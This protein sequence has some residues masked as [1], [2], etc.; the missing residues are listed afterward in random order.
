M[1]K[2]LLVVKLIALCI[3][4]VLAMGLVL[5]ACSDDSMIRPNKER[6][7]KQASAVV[8]YGGRQAY[9]DKTSVLTSFYN[10][11]NTI[12]QYYQM[13]YIGA[14][15]FAA[16]AENLETTFDDA[17]ESLAKN[18]LFKL[19]C[20]EYLG[21]QSGRTNSADTKGKTYDFSKI[22][23]QDRY[24]VDRIAELES[25]L[26]VE[27]KNKAIFNV[28]HSMDEQLDKY[29]AEITEQRS[30][31]EEEE[32]EE[33]VE[34]PA[35]ENM[36]SLVLT[37]APRKVCYEKGEALSLKGMVLT[38]NYSKIF[39]NATAV[40]NF[41][42]ENTRY[43]KGTASDVTG[44][45]KV[46]YSTTVDNFED[47]GTVPDITGITELGDEEIN[48]TYGTKKVSFNVTIIEARPHRKQEAELKGTEEEHAHD[49]TDSHAHTLEDAV[50]YGA[51][52]KMLPLEKFSFEVVKGENES[53]DEYSIRKEAM[54][55]LNKYLADNFASYNYYYL[56]ELET[57]LVNTCKELSTRTY[58][59]QEDIELAYKNKVEQD[60]NQYTTEKGWISAVETSYTNSS[61]AYTLGDNKGIYFIKHILFPF[62]TEQNKQITALSDEKGSTDDA[63]QAYREIFAKQIGVWLSNPDFNTTDVC[64]AHQCTECKKFD[65]DADDDH[66]C[67]EC[68]GEVE[69]VTEGFDCACP[70]CENYDGVETY[71]NSG[72]ALCP[73]TDCDCKVCPSNEYID[74]D[75]NVQTS[76]INVLELVGADKDGLG[77]AIANAIDAIKRDSFDSEV[78][79]RQ[80]VIAEFDKWIYMADGANSGMEDVLKNE[81]MGNIATPEDYDSSY[82]ESFTN[83]AREL[84]LKGFGSY[85]WC[86]SQYGIHFIMIT[87]YTAD[88]AVETGKL[89]GVDTDFCAY[90]F[91]GYAKNADGSFSK[92]VNGGY[93]KVEN[94]RVIL[95]S[96]YIVDT[97][98]YDKNDKTY[99]TKEEYDRYL[100]TGEKTGLG[101]EGTGDDAKY[102]HD[103]ENYKV[104]LTKAQADALIASGERDVR[105]SEESGYYYYVEKG[106]LEFALFE[107]IVTNKQNDLYTSFQKTFLDNNIEGNVEYFPNVY[108]D[109]VKDL[110]EQMQG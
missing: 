94:G 30:E 24:I 34:A 92:S 50:E 86:V 26:N 69:V 89:D 25:L 97:N 79:Y 18:A 66:V 29:I 103:N 46:T 15:Q 91:G 59:T 99:I 62:T 41:F 101:V 8:N 60:L 10:Y 13:G 90:P 65:I 52:G 56:K 35:I 1:K 72:Y 42:A 104:T 7:A 51:D 39:D 16:I 37:S 61:V 49:S 95:P 109:S 2:K 11:Y 83:L 85:G 17:N 81:S 74:L 9:V 88:V 53:A 78:A 21:Q 28:N 6:T 102:Y 77:G 87:G 31:A 47:F 76:A 20:I 36:V 68:G 67:D 73:L 110:K 40:D 38:I 5:T 75:G 4:V 23:E 107:S 93:A 71:P 80:A 108:A 32:K 70:L 98:A 44:G 100:L 19:Y 96:N 84:A 54:N 48:I 14:E 22:A 3:A 106:T 12:Y 57:V 33:E 82:V 105:G 58:V 63:I 64:D 55:K 45:V 43:V 27:E